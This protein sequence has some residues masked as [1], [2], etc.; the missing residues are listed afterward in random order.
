MINHVSE[1][2]SSELAPSLGAFGVRQTPDI[3]QLMICKLKV[4]AE[5]PSI[6]KDKTNPQTHSQYVSLDAINKALMPVASKH[7]IVITP[8]PIS[9]SEYIGIAVRLDHP[10]SGQWIVFP[11]YYISRNGNNRNTRASQ[12]QNEGGILT[13]CKRYAI[14]AVF[15]IVADDDLDG[16]V[17]NNNGNQYGNGYY[18]NNR[19]YKK[20]NYYNNNQQNS[21]NTYYQNNN[22]YARNAQQMGYNQPVQQNTQRTQNYTPNTSVQQPQ[23]VQYN[24]QQNTPVQKQNNVNPQQQTPQPVQA[25]KSQQKQY[26]SQEQLAIQNYNNVLQRKST[27][28]QVPSDQL[29]NKVLEQVNNILRG[30]GVDYTTLSTEQQANILSQELE[31]IGR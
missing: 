10:E 7:G 12:V 29:Q 3:K 30:Q 5:L 22:N 20:N 25:S 24:T 19:Q 11:P 26:T 18:N 21:R 9:N 2:H 17:S 27:E 8:I 4:Q 28:L 15:N 14:S 16:N 1:Q 23:N 31:K 6:T 13:Y